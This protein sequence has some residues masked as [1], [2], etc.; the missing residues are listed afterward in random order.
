MN[1]RDFAEL[2]IE[3]SASRRLFVSLFWLAVV[4]LSVSFLP[5]LEVET[6]TESILNRASP[7]WA[8]YEKSLDAFGGDEFVAFGVPVDPSNPAAAIGLIQSLSR[9]LKSIESV[10]RVES[11]ATLPWI[12]A[13]DPGV[14]EV[15]PPLAGVSA[16]VGLLRLR[17]AID[18][19]WAGRGLAASPALDYL[20]INAVIP[21]AGVDHEALISQ[22]E[23][24]VGSEEVDV[25]GVPV[26]RVET[27]R[28]SQEE[29]W[30]LGGASA[31][32]LLFISFAV[33]AR[34]RLVGLMTIPG[35]VGVTAMLG[36]MA[37]LSR[38]LVVTTIM[39][40]PAVFA[41]G[42][43]YAAHVLIAWQSRQIAGVGGVARAVALSGLTTTVGFLAGSV[44]GIEAVRTVAVYGAVGVFVGT[45]CSLTLV[46]AIL[47]SGEGWVDNG[48]RLVR[49]NHLASRISA[50]SLAIQPRP[51]LFGL[52]AV[53]TLATAGLSRL[54]V[55]T[56]ATE[57]I[58]VGDPVRDA[59]ERMSD[60]VSGISPLSFVLEVEEG[61]VLSGERIALVRNLEEFIRSQTG[62]GATASASMLISEMDS[63]M[64]RDSALLSA[65]MAEQYALLLEG[66]GF[67]RPFVSADRLSTRLAV[68]ANENGSK[69]L[70][71]I[72]RLGEDWWREN[73]EA[74]TR[75]YAT[76]VMYEF[77]RAEDAIAIGQLVAIAVAAT[78]LGLVLFFEL[79]LGWA[80]V[81]AILANAIPLWV[82]YG[83]MGALG[84]PIDAGT[85]LIGS[86]ALGI[87]VDDSIH[88]L[89]RY[90]LALVERPVE[91]AVRSA[92]AGAMLPVTVS[93]VVLIG[94][95]VVL[96]ASGFTLTRNLGL[97]T[98]S[99]VFFCLVS[100]L[101]LL[102]ALL[103]ARG[104][105][106][107]QP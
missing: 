64:S 35:L 63:A 39:L 101:V 107:S 78:V 22:M 88:F 58:P 82:L 37:A 94:A 53:L 70:Q 51:L 73:G 31:A 49:L 7:E 89:H 86:L 5:R 52:V 1:R 99:V 28:R 2:A 75:L 62:V 84:L 40:P 17:A 18:D 36:L 97:L 38:P 96:G 23:D 57:W 4:L 9:D 67:F 106:L 72:A 69:E 21:S 8:L 6:S 47:A 12:R 59:Y 50:R 102:P 83:G 15:D 19:E 66:S 41:L 45:A 100:D 81:S 27:N 30:R 14:I 90:R 20:A 25:S 29:L 85:V 104:E 42:S 79:G 68:Y 44:V 93:S 26:F 92:S 46:P 10:E 54:T 56:D 43:A 76:G 16:E 98:A 71:S 87:G 34:A 3:W 60:R 13:T 74:G 61:T 91:S 95:F 48:K 105:A 103:R 24:A 80:L 55:S 65:D 32:V 11:A 33:F 77:A